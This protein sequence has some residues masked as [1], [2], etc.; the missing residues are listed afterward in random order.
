MRNKSNKK[1]I[2]LIVSLMVAFLVLPNRDGDAQETAACEPMGWF[3]TDFD[4]K[5]HSVFFYDG[6]YYIVSIYNPGEQFF[7]YARSKDLCN[8]E[9]LSP[10][11]TDRSSEWESANVW[12]PFVLELDGVYYMYYTGV[13]GPYPN[14]TQSIMLA[15]T[16]NP[17]DPDSWVLQGLIFQ[18]DHPGTTWL[19]G[20]W[21]DCRDPY[22]LKVGDTFY[23]Y[24]TARDIDGGI[25]GVATANNPYFDNAWDLGSVM[26]LPNPDGLVTQAAQNYAIQ[27]IS[28]IRN[29]E[30]SLVYVHDG[31][32][33]L[34]YNS[35]GE[36]FRIGA[37]PIGP[38][39]DEYPIKPGWA[40]E[41][42]SG[43]DG[44]TYTSYLSDT[45]DEYR[46]TITISPL[47]W[48]EFYFPPRPFIGDEQFHF[49]LPQ[50]LK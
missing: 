26:K 3:P 2:I 13:K 29:P 10:I 28:S 16:T 8:W 35:K 46:Y 11:L 15:T 12:A 20:H 18:P 48:D 17:A 41:V 40:H 31:Y 37:S 23:L 32:Y 43:M 33:Y 47:N 1:I 45:Y 24:Y 49:L 36:H 14:F 34:F 22:V 6:Y 27:R 30:S 21:A 5:D 39:T 19:D 42:W 44:Q 7:A 50:I 4:L 9:D 25:V 38:W